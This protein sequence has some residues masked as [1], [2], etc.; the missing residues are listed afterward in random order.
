MPR[1]PIFDNR[2]FSARSPE[3][4]ATQRDRAFQEGARQRLI[5]ALEEADGL[6]PFRVEVEHEQRKAERGGN[7]RTI[8]DIA[9]RWQRL[10]SEARR[11]QDPA[12]VRVYRDAAELAVKARAEG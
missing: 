8:D 5:E 3:R 7:A 11:A 4:G 1:R 2:S 10:A 12:K 6:E 9:R